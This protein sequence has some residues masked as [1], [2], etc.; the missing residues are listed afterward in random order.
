MRL[1]GA[2]GTSQTYRVALARILSKVGDLPS[3]RAI[4][5]DLVAE[6]GSLRRESIRKTLSVLAM[7]L[8]HEGI[9]PNP[10]RDTRVKLPRWQKTRKPA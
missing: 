1:D 8:D 5:A 7:I 4:V 6:F 10:A 2:A 3:T 9:Q